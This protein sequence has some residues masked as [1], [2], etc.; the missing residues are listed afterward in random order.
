MLAFRTG[1]CSNTSFTWQAKNQPGDGTAGVR[2]SWSYATE[3]WRSALAPSLPKIHFFQRF[4]AFFQ[5]VV[6]H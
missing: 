2:F 6:S 3:A 5:R 4:S 1:N